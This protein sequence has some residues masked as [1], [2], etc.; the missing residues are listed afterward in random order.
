[1]S[2]G[3]ILLPILAKIFVNALCDGTQ[4]TI[5]N[6]TDDL[7]LGGVVDIPNGCAALQGDLNRLE[8]WVNRKLMEFNNANTRFL[9]LVRTNPRHQYRLGA[10]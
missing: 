9:S 1:M 10:N 2:P 7:K 6:S 5:H 4:C 8:K 3:S